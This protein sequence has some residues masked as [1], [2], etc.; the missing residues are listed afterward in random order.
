MDFD[1]RNEAMND[2]KMDVHVINCHLKLSA[3]ATWLV[4]DSQPI[5]G[6]SDFTGHHTEPPSPYSYCPCIRAEFLPPFH[7]WKVAKLNM[8]DWPPL[9]KKG[10][11][12]VFKSDD[13]VIIIEWQV[14]FCAWSS[15][16]IGL[17]RMLPIHDMRLTIHLGFF[18]SHLTKRL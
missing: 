17:P 4:V 11:L 12:R 10:G 1:F 18:M 6:I 14:I 9:W 8:K 5:M 16:L 7:C 3:A 2:N 13:T 15:S